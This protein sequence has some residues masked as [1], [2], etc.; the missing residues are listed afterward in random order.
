MCRQIGVE[1]KLETI[2]L[3][4]LM[5]QY[6]ANYDELLND[7]LHLSSRGSEMLFSALK[8]IVSK[9][10]EPELRFQFPYYRD[11]KPG[12]SKIDQ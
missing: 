8:E 1:K 2:D 3:H 9:N 12:Q 5:T 10:I 4:K 11:L 6:G 7:G